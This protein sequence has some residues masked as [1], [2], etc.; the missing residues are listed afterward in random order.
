MGSLKAVLGTRRYV[1]QD[2]GAE[3]DA[4]I[5]L[6]P[7]R[8][9]M[10]R[11]QPC[12]ARGYTAVDVFVVLALVAVVALFLLMSMPRGR[13]QARLTSCQRNLAQI[14]VALALYDQSQQRLPTIAAPASI[15]PPS[16][17]G[18]PGP[19]KLL[20]ETLGW[21]DL[22]GLGAAPGT[23]PPREGRVRGEV[24]IPG[25]VCG[26][27]PNALAGLFPAPINYRATTGDGSRSHNGPFAPGRSINLAR[28]EASDG[29]S[30]TAA[31][32]E[33]LMGDNLPFHPALWNYAL[34]K[35]AIQGEGCP[36][37]HDTDAPWRGDAGRSWAFADYRSTLYNHALLPNGQP[38]CLT[39]DGQMAFMGASSGHVRGVNLLMLDGSVKLVL[40]TV[41]PKIWRDYAAI[42]KLDRSA[43]SSSKKLP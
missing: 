22:R 14:G 7:H 17:A 8:Q 37:G 9:L 11:T 10:N 2:A 35:G 30:Y 1:V 43:N 39:A 26:S 24:P 16:S 25:F 18:S 21:S 20:L 33:R 38:S 41:A 15:D 42:G 3:R 36:V 34:V 31:F 12:R 40:T 19:L 27:D 32:S 6:P 13:E 28:I 4:R 23:L 29:S 5:Q